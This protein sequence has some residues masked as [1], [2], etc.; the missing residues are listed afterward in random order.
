MKQVARKNWDQKF[1]TQVLVFFYVGYPYTLSLFAE[2]AFSGL[3]KVKA[4]TT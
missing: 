2:K 3:F 4:R 1:F